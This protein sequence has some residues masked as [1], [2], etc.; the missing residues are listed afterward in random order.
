MLIN[1]KG[2]LPGSE[3]FWRIPTEEEETFLYYILAAGY[4]FCDFQYEILRSTYGKSCLFML[5]LSG[6][7]GIDNMGYS[8]KAHANE[9][10]LVNCE[11]KHH[12]YASPNVDFVY[13][14]FKGINA[15]DLVSHLIEKNDGCVFKTKNIHEIRKRFMTIITKQKNLCEIKSYEYAEFIYSLLCLLPEESD[16]PKEP[17]GYV[18]RAK[19]IIQKSLE[20]KITLEELSDGVGLSQSYFLR[21]FKE[22]TGMT[23][24]EYVAQ[25]K[26]EAS[27]VLLRTTDMTIQEVAFHL[28]Y[29]SSSS[30][31]NAF[32]SRVGLTPKKYREFP[33]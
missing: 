23:P 18:S 7:M 8:Q 17:E 19:M 27:K 30:F 25:K 16:T 24:M 21:L 1:E 10:V 26:I 22:E 5:I 14:F 31:N 11:K 6:T 15:C 12:Y 33:I 4:Y 3:V 28:A 29:S 13:V 2:C 32:V 9:V 20:K